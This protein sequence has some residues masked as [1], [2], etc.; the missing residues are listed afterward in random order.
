MISQNVNVFD[1]Q[2]F[3]IDVLAMINFP[4][5][6]S[7][8]ICHRTSCQLCKTVWSGLYIHLNL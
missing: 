2:P 4:F 3:I 1:S 6:D 8:D 7:V 5:S